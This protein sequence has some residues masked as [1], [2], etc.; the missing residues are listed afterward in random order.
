MDFAGDEVGEFLAEALGVPAFEEGV[1]VP[2]FVAVDGA[3]DAGDFALAGDQGGVDL[4]AEAD[5]LGGDPEGF[6]EAFFFGGVFAG[7]EDGGAVGLRDGEAAFNGGEE[8]VACFSDGFFGEI[9]DAGEVCEGHGGAEGDIIEELIF[10][11]HARGDVGFKGE[12]LA[13]G[14]DF[15]EDGEVLRLEAGSGADFDVEL[16]GVDDLGGFGA[17]FGAGVAHPAHV[18]QGIKP[19]AHF[20]VDVGEV[21]DVVDGVVELV[22]GEGAAV[23]G[24][25]GVGFFEFN[26]GE[27][28]DGSPEGGGVG[29]AEHARADLG[30]EHVG[31]DEAGFQP[32]DFDILIAGVADFFEGGVGEEFP[33]GAEGGT[34][35][36][37]GVDELDAVISGD[38]DEAEDGVVGVFA[39]ELGIEGEALGGAEVVADAEEGL[40]GGDQ[41]CW[42]GGEFH[43]GILREGAGGGKHHTEPLRVG[44][45][46]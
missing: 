36:G 2:G 11:E 8:L 31:G 37:E 25:E 24:G 42:G 19:A 23:P 6:G 9:A 40:R 38:L 21:A 13:E 3:G 44:I 4:L 46:S 5:G 33:E 15:A 1:A 29:D 12:L 41:R 35:E 30:I 28:G 45:L 32:G 39:D 43:G 10:E 22:L 20:G 26:A 16:A 7:D 17:H 18:A 34:I 27:V 14:D